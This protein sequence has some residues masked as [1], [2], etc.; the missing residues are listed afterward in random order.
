MRN[1][2]IN[3]LAYVPQDRHLLTGLEYL[4]LVKNGY[5]PCHR[6]EWA[7]YLAAKTNLTL[8][9]LNIVHGEYEHCFNYADVILLHL[10][11]LGYTR[12]TGNGRHE[13]TEAGWTMLETNPTHIDRVEKTGR[14]PVQAK[15]AAIK[16][17]PARVFTRPMTVERYMRQRNI[18]NYFR[19]YA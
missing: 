18:P 4:A 17:V 3:S 9:Q 14:S 7:E 12:M 10:R 11:R 1:Y 6:R 13:V 15:K 5:D 16:A 8:E 2:T 19:A